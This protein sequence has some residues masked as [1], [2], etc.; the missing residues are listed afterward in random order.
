[1]KKNAISTKFNKHLTAAVAEGFAPCMTELRGSYS[2]VCGTQLVLAKDNERIVMWMEEKHDYGNHKAP[3]TVHLFVAR[4]ALGKG[5]TCE[6][7]YMWPQ[8]WKKHLIDEM[9][10][11]EVTA[12]REGW[13]V[14]DPADATHAKET[15]YA[16]YDNRYHADAPR[17]VEVTDRLLAIVRRKKGFKTIKRENLSVVKSHNRWVFRNTVSHREVVVGA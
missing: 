15:H 17:K 5:E 9:T 1:M 13:Y 14:D 11:Y 6:W 4:F 12:R 8:D 16:R 3:D 7:N 2:G 10:V